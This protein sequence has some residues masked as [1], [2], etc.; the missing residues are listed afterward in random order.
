MAIKSIRLKEFE[1]DQERWL[2]LLQVKDG[3]PMAM[4][5]LRRVTMVS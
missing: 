3:A 5:Y 1:R 2:K 4:A